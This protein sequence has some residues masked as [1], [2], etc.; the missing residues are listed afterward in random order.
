MIDAEKR[1]EKSN[2]EEEG[3]RKGKHPSHEEGQRWRLA[4]NLGPPVEQQVSSV[5][6]ALCEEGNWM[7]VIAF[8]TWEELA[9]NCLGP[10]PDADGL[11]KL[12]DVSGGGGGGSL[13]WVIV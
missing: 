4:E 13:P 11:S 1:E 7:V 12:M 8:A 9:S 6:Q 10:G 2:F 3:N 5:A